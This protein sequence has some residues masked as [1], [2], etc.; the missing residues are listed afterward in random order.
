[1]HSG[2]RDTLI[3]VREHYWIL[4]GRQLVK[5]IVSGCYICKKLKVKAAQQITAPLP[6]DR[7]TES[8][9]F[10]VTGADFAGPFYV[11]TKGQPVKVYIAL[12][13]C[14]VTRAVHLELVS[15]QT[16]ENFL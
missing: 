11:K 5:R 9:P 13:T 1:M 12:F 8:S 6:R 4:R 15:D 3:Q 2:V 14:A 10:E 16:T 7:E